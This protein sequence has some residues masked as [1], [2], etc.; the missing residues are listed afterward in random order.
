M[1]VLLLAT[2]I[3][4]AIT[5]RT[6]RL[7]AEQLRGA[8]LASS[9]PTNHNAPISTTRLDTINVFLSSV[10]NV[11]VEDLSAERTLISN[12]LRDE[13]IFSLWRFEDAPADS[14]LKNSYLSKAKRCHIF[15]IVI[16]RS[17]TAAV[18]EELSVAIANKRPVIAFV[19]TVADRSPEAENL[20]ATLVAA[21]IRYKTVHSLEQLEFELPRALYATVVKFYERGLTPEAYALVLIRSS[22]LREIDLRRSDSET[23]PPLIPSESGLPTSAAREVTILIT[24]VTP[25]Y[26][27]VHPDQLLT[28]YGHV[29]PPNMD[30][31]VILNPF[32]GPMYWVQPRASRTSGGAWEVRCFLPPRD[33]VK[34][35]TNFRILAF[36]NPTSVLREGAILRDWPDAAARSQYFYYSLGH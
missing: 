22:S 1:L 27:W 34:L 9:L 30:V 4:L 6:G 20:I 13:G 8:H 16:G 25:E 24:G 5:L 10:M 12:C 15:L 14:E 35:Q 26:S 29:S 11:E 21:D 19:K 17:S 28:V 33:L 3:V 36:A 7:L 31:F 2:L 32:P 18:A 23:Q